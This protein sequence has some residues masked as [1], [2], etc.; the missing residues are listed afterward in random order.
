MTLKPYEA[1]QRTVVTTKGGTRRVCVEPPPMTARS[2]TL[3]V[4]GKVDAATYAA[5]EA[6]VKRST[7][8]EQLYQLDAMNLLLQY[9]LYRLCELGMNGD[10]KDGA[11]FEQYTKIVDKILALTGAQAEAVKQLDILRQLAASA[12]AVID[13]QK[14]LLAEKEEDLTQLRQQ[15]ASAQTELADGKKRLSEIAGASAAERAEIVSALQQQIAAREK[16]NRELLEEIGRRQERVGALEE[17]LKSSASTAEKLIDA[18]R[19]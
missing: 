19:N 13:T 18:A 9:A 3:D 4:N 2:I 16:E 12:Q 15:I 5:V 7:S 17:T 6:A 11:A 8:H 1:Q 14:A 10:I